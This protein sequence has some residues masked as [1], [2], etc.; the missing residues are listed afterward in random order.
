M[1]QFQYKEGSIVLPRFKLQYDMS[2]NDGLNALG[3]GVAID[4]QRADFSGM[5]P[6]QGLPR[7]GDAQN[8]CGGER[9]RHAQLQP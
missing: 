8:F 5:T 6:A 1:K 2:L 3:M 4:R 7:S 9:R